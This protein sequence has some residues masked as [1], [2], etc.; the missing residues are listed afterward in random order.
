[1]PSV[2]LASTDTDTKQ[3]NFSVNFVRIQEISFG[4]VV[5]S[6]PLNMQNISVASQTS[7]D[8]TTW[9]Y[10]QNLDSGANIFLSLM[11]STSATQIS[12]ANQTYA[13]QPGVVK[14]TISVA[15]WPFK[16]IRNQLQIVTVLGTQQSE[17]G[18]PQTT[19]KSDYSGNV[20]SVQYTVGGVS[21][22]STLL[23]DALVDQEP[24]PLGVNFVT[25]N[26]SNLLIMTLP[27]FWVNAVV[28]P[29]YSVL[30]DPTIYDSEDDC[31]G[32]S[33]TEKQQKQNKQINTTIIVVVSVAGG[34]VLASAGAATYWGW[35]K[36]REFDLQMSAL[37]RKVSQTN[38]T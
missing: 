21:M 11:T 36:R 27:H 33:I 13:L 12:F 17:A 4:E 10:N 23:Q 15:Y 14:S 1:M 18:C 29:D 20:R 35:K 32:S 7:G 6:V 16:S 37:S 34:V 2:V 24:S 3:I 19:V 8:V 38:M 9:N 22:Y 31:L 30:L 28:D 26:G 25:Q 5:A